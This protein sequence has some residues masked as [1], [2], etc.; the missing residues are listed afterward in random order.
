MGP[1]RCTL[2]GTDPWLCLNKHEKRGFREKFTEKQTFPVKFK[3]Q[4]Q[5]VAQTC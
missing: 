1:A 5:L 3:T 4:K 2:H